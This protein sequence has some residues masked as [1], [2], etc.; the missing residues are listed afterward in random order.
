M[1]KLKKILTSIIKK[2]SLKSIVN[3]KLQIRRCYE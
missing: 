3:K 2:F 1:T